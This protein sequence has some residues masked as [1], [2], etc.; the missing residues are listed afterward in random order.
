MVIDGCTQ[1]GNNGYNNPIDGFISVPC[2][3]ILHLHREAPISAFG[4]QWSPGLRGDD[5]GTHSLNLNANLILSP[6]FIE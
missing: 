2:C 3:A 4:A 1:Q 6:S 5:R